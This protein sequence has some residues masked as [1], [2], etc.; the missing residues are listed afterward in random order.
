MYKITPY[1]LFEA[2]QFCSPIVLTY[3]SLI[4]INGNRLPQKLHSNG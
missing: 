3:H 2:E 1:Y 4:N